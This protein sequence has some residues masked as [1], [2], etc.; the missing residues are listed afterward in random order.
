MTNVTEPLEEPPV[1]G[2]TSLPR[3]LEPPAALEDRVVSALAS[4]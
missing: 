1:Q 3:D 2:M 4:Q